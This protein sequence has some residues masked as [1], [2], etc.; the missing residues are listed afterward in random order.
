[1]DIDLN[2]Y[3]RGNNARVVHLNDLTLWFSYATPIAFTVAGSG[4]LYVRENE[5]NNTTGGHMTVID[6]GDK[7]HRLPTAEFERYMDALF[8]RG[9]FLTALV[10]AEMTK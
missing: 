9:G 1:M 7:R 5:W 10:A 6:R 2:Y 3:A 4:K 8:P